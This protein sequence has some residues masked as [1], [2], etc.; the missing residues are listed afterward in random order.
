ME[1]TLKSI[2]STLDK[3]TLYERVD[4]NTIETLTKSNL[5][6]EVP[7]KHIEKKF[8]NELE[9]I[10]CYLDVIE[11]DKD[12]K[13]NNIAIAKVKYMKTA[14]YTFGRVYPVKSL[15]LGTIRRELRHTIARDSNSNNQPLYKDI[16]ISNC[17]PVIIYQMMKKNDVNIVHLKDYVN[18]RD[19]HLKDVMDKYKVSRDNAKNLFI[20][21]L[22]FG[23][24][25]TW[26]K[27]VL[28]SK[29][30]K[31][32]K[33][34]T[35]LINERNI[36]GEVIEKA[37]PDI[38]QEVLK[39][40]N[41]SHTEM[42]RS[43]AS[44]VSIWC[45]EVECRILEQ[46]Y[47]YC[48]KKKYIN[49]KVAVLCYD[50]IMIPIDNYKDSI[51][52][53]FEQ[54]IKDKFELDL[55]FECK[56]MDRNYT[57]KEIKESLKKEVEEV[58]EVEEDKDDRKDDREFLKGLDIFSDVNSANL[59]YQYNKN[60]YLYIINSGWYAYNEFNRLVSSEKEYPVKMQ[61]SI[62][63]YLNEYI[64]PIRN[65]MKPNNPSYIKDCKNINMLLKNINSVNYIDKIQ[66]TL[67]QLYTQDNINIDSNSDLLAFNNKVFDYKT[68][69]FRDIKTT[70]YICTTTGYDYQPSNKKLRKD[71][72]KLIKSIFEN[73]KVEEYF[74]QTKALSLFGN[75]SE[76]LY[77]QIGSGGNGK[78]ILSSL[79]RKALGDY[80]MTTENTFLTSSFKQGSANPTLSSSR[81]K[82]N[83]IISE[84]SEENEFGASVT[85]NAPFVK[86]ITGNDEIITRDL[87]KSNF[88]FIPQFTPFIQCN[89]LPNI[90]NLDKGLQRRIKVIK[91]PLSF[92]N[93]P[94]EEHE[95]KIDITLKSTIENNTDFCL[96]YLLLLID[97]A[98]DNK[99][100][101]IITPKEVLD[102]TSNYFTENNPVKIFLDEFIIKN[103]ESK[104][105]A[106][107]LF[108]YYNTKSDDKLS[109]KAF[110]TS[111]RSNGISDYLSGGY[112]YF[113]GIEIKD[114]EENNDD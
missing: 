102:Q 85:L 3:I 54:L 92:V 84:P 23:E 105:K 79:E 108:E 94:V 104:I 103:K 19:K 106:S 99:D 82:R 24:F 48:K 95:R 9:Q 52:D 20:R 100:K 69:K 114:E 91:F 15:S 11:K 38:Y 111:M 2:K 21:I 89:N 77:V 98:K 4:I 34:I 62:I 8:K 58:E 73:D 87:Y 37:N 60:K 72:L 43:E 67:Q 7:H 16:D 47:M 12:N 26:A 74:I 51:C 68:C 59:Y 28:K 56:D 45:Q 27:D 93:K 36:Y 112:R 49:D 6:L 14:G 29:D 42:W 86:L 50:G 83:M 17:H 57:L 53:E 40:K 61:Q 5:L 63:K 81:N 90:K 1:L 109:S 75:K 30:I 107:E 66:K 71:V 31:P 13:D 78:G 80:T 25:E 41:K 113:K 46:L 33:F 22:Y 39:N 10:N 96:E 88:K 32:L 55:K 97:C 18:N 70:D 35:D 44:I 65:R 101:E 110:Y 64:T 76:S